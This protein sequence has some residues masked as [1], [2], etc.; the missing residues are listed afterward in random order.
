MSLSACIIHGDCFD[1]LSK[2]PDESVDLVLTDPPYAIHYRSNRRVSRPKFDHF[3]GDKPGDWIETFAEESYRLLRTNRHLY[4][5][6]RHDTYPLFFTAFQRAGFRMKRTLIWVKNNHGSGDLKG[7]YAPR[8]E[9][10]IYA[11][12]G[13]RELRGKREDN[14]LEFNKVHTG[15][16]LHPTQ[17]PLELLRLL[18]EK[19]S[20][21]GEMVLDPYAGVL[22]TAVAAMDL[23]RSFVAIDNSEEFI[24]KGVERIQKHRKISEYEIDVNIRTDLLKRRLTNDK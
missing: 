17:K 24:R 9:W 13:R 22:S 2:L 10:I 5:F 12:K 8:D 4:C 19:S 6:C 1:I 14:I 15:Q 7:D 11:Q 3:E 18:I 23:E 16:L 20:S 21:P